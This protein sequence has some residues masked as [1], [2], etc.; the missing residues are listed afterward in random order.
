MEANPQSEKASSSAVVT[1]APDPLIVWTARHYLALWAVTLAAAIAIDGL[2]QAR[3]DRNTAL[4]LLQTVNSA[5][6]VIGLLVVFVPVL[7]LTA[8]IAV[9]SYADHHNWPSLSIA[10]LVALFTLTLFISPI[11]YWFPFAV[12]CVVAWKTGLSVARRRARAA[13]AAGPEQPPPRPLIEQFIFFHLF[14]VVALVVV[15]PMWLPTERITFA[16]TTTTVGYVL[17]TDSGWVSLLEEGDRAVIRVRA[18][19]IAA[20]QICSL[21]DG[22]LLTLPE[23]LNLTRVEQSPPCTP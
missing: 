15:A 14:T 10:I 13:V 6:I 16:D 2:R 19:D 7:I 18:D 8:D 22:R 20:R 9:F 17:T 4:A 3:G 11:L 21:Q 23:W 12:L 1:A 5:S